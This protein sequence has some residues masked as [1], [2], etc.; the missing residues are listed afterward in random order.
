MSAKGIILEENGEFGDRFKT[1]HS[2]EMGTSDGNM[3]EEATT[4]PR[5]EM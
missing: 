1:G 2:H 3:S 5:G 4:Q